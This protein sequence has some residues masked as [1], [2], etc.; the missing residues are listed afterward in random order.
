MATNTILRCGFFPPPLHHHHRHHLQIWKIRTVG[1]E[2][3]RASSFVTTT[4][5]H[6]KIRR[7]LVFAVNQDAEKS[8]K[9]TVEVDRLI[10]VLRD[11]NPNELQKLVVENVLAF[12]EGFW[13]RLAARTETCKSEDDKACLIVLL[14][15]KDYEELALSVMSIVDRLVHKTNEKI[16]SATDILKKILQPVVDAVEEIS[17]PPRDPEALVL[18]EKE[19]NQREQE[20][21]LDE[22]FL[23]EV[24]AQLRQAKE[25]GDKPGL[26][27]MLQKV[28]QL[29]ASRVLSKRSYAK[30]GNEVL[31]A[32]EFL[33]NI[34][35]APEEEWNRLLINGLTL[36]KG[37]VTPE[38]LYAVI[39]KRIE[40][41][42]IRTEGGSYQQRVLTEYLRGIQS[43][44]EE[45]FV[46]T[47]TI[48][49]VRDLKQNNH[50]HHP[51]R[52][53]CVRVSEGMA[54]KA[55][56]K[57][58]EKGEEQGKDLD[59][60][61][62]PPLPTPPEKPL[63]GDCCGSGCV[64]CVWDIYYEE[65]EDYNNLLLQTQTQSKSKS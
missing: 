4:V 47:Q 49:N 61:P 8:F 58:P 43:R 37:E 23:S 56:E 20:G 41:T 65:L 53:G 28:L 50:H 31:K 25:D 63:P 22:G 26:E 39:K 13:I 12:N 19:L 9:K 34:I 48:G 21:Q 35:K 59:T 1:M 27:A 33:E 5:T 60:S 6:R 57:P 15:Q 36:G 7:T 30:K 10:D 18:M 2:K 44:A 64:R 11:A 32:E 14:L 16:E 62:S 52:L 45:G 3:G 54:D 29:Y 55:S 38:E 17:W 51:C 42:L 46:N 40:R 24:N